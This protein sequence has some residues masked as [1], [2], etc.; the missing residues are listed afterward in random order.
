MAVTLNGLY[1]AMLFR[2]V[3]I[4][5]HSLQIWL[6]WQFFLFSKVQIMLPVL[7]DRSDV[8]LFQK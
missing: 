8:T 2:N 1:I 5:I 3:R 6:T 7:D 4:L